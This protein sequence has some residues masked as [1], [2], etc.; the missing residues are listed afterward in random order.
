MRGALPGTVMPGATS[1]AMSYVAVEGVIGVG[2]T[3]VGRLKL[4]VSCCAS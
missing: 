2:K 1:T 4:T 3:T